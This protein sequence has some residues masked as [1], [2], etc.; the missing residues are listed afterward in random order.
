MYVFVGGLCV[1]KCYVP[2]S[3]AGSGKAKKAKLTTAAKTSDPVPVATKRAPPTA[4]TAL[5]SPAHLTPSTSMNPVPHK[6]PPKAAPE[7]RG[8][9]VGPIKEGKGTKVPSKRT[10]KI[11]EPVVPEPAHSDRYGG[12]VPED[13][14]EDE[15]E[16]K[17]MLLI[18]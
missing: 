18:L 10:K 2:N 9:G 13:V 8:K 1:C 6:K 4:V 12:A 3:P 7:K 5:P 14:G 17:G 16:E 11:P 15:D